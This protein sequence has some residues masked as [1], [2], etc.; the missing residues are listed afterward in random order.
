[1]A[2]FDLTQYDPQA[3]ADQMQLDRK[4]AIAKML[5]DQAAQ[6]FNDAQMVGGR[7]LQISPFQALAKIGTGY[8]AGRAGD[9][10]DA[11]KQAMIEAL[12]GKRNAWMNEMPKAGTTQVPA[13]Y[14]QFDS[15]DTI[16]GL[17]NTQTTNPTSQDYLGWAMKGMNIDPNAAQFGMKYADIAE[18]RDTR[19]Q[20][21]KEM[22]QERQ[23]SLQAQIQARK[24]AQDAQ[25][26]ARRESQQAALDAQKMA[27]QQNF[28]NQME[29]RKF[30]AMLAAA[31][32][33]PQAP[34]SVIG[35]DGNPMYVPPAQAYGKQPF[36]AA[37]EQKKTLQ[38]QQ[39]SQN[40]I[41]SQQVLDQA[42]ALYMHPGRQAGTGAS[43]FLSMI[44]GTDAKGFKSNL[45]TFKAQTFVPMVSALKG[46]GALS[47][48][49]GKKLS[50]SVGALDPSMPEAEFAASLQN[51]TRTLYQKAK[52]SGLNV[53]MPDFA[54]QAQPRSNIAA[55]ASK[56][57][58][59]SNW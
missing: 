11:K 51:V 52:A 55:P 56:Q 39:R 17:S 8:M 7:V 34:V 6:P 29:L 40:T 42:A 15:T 27:A 14:D 16:P 49:E 4:M 59:V 2:Q 31:N 22:A 50:E 10:A 35:P 43:S 46:M 21:Y 30:G 12:A 9:A 44:P 47:D 23:D 25:L 58:T 36:N 41:S 48:A 5:R 28:Q 54:G 45:D 37:F 57:P 20:Q 26:Q 38:D 24:D 53:Q 1:M 33:Q 18:N 13:T 32:R 19:T 3:A